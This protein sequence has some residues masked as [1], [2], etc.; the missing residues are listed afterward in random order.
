MIEESEFDTT[1]IEQ[2]NYCCEIKGIETALL[3]YSLQ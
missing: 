2:M 3:L 1:L